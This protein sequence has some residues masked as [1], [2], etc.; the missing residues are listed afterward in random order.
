MPS[1]STSRPALVDLG[2]PGLDDQPLAEVLPVASTAAP[3]SERIRRPS[4]WSKWSTTTSIMSPG[5]G[6]ARPELLDRDD[7]LALGAEVDED[8]LAADAR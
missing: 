1:T 4:A 2:D 8:A 5:F 3:L 6:Q 7:A